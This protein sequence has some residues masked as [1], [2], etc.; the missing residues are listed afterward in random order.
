MS[1]AA[2]SERAGIKLARPD[3]L[4]TRAFIDGAWIIGE[5][6]IAHGICEALDYGML[7]L[8]TG[9]ISTEVGGCKGSGIGR[10]GSHYGLGEFQELR[11]VCA[12]LDDG[13]TR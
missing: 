10:E 1:G 4:R 3:I 2:S 5:P 13:L 7:G 11:T 12:R 9:L 6:R 8:N